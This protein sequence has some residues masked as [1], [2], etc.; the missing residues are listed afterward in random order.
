MQ[1]EIIQSLDTLIA[2]ADEWNNLL[3][4]C[5]ASHVPFLRHEYLTT[6]WQ[7]LGG[8][9][10]EKGE[11]YTVI[12]RTEDGTLCG[13]APLFFTDNREGLPALMLLGS[14]EIS[15]YLDFIIRETDVETFT[16]ALFE[17]LKTEAA[18]SWQVLDFYNLLDNSPSI[19][20][21]ASAAHKQGWNFEMERLQPCPYI[22]LPSDW[23]T[24]LANLKKKHR[25][26]IRRKLRRADRSYT[27]C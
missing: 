16:N 10:W 20:A 4:C 19:P 7:T 6:W 8:G 22:E 17:L 23:D 27:R 2:L 24:Y 3:T 21:I 13:I 5:S 25:H 1:I 18:P 12:A 11:L 26:E 15:D 14:I 9:E